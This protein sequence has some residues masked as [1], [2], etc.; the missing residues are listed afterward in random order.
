MSTARPPTTPAAPTLRAIASGLGAK[1]VLVYPAADPTAV[2][3][4]IDEDVARDPWDRA[5]SY[6]VRMEDFSGG[7][8]AARAFGLACDHAVA[9]VLAAGGRDNLAGTLD[10]LADERRRV[11]AD[12]GLAT[13]DDFGRVRH[14]APD[15]LNPR[16]PLLSRNLESGAVVACRYTPYLARAEAVL[17][18]GDGRLH[19]R[20]GLTASGSV[21]LT[22]T[23]RARTPWK[24]DLEWAHP[25]SPGF[26][27]M[28]AHAEEVFGRA[29]AC[30]RDEVLSVV[31][32]LHWW[33]AHVSRYRRGSAAIADMSCKLV[34]EARGIAVPA[35]RA[36]IAPDLEAYVTPLGEYRA[37]YPTLF[38]QLPKEIE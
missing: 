35:W 24:D 31:A 33:L 30:P 6:V 4:A 14:E 12:A 13:A 27:A 22:H 25:P 34:L 32:E 2:L 7:L 16:T 23:R 17:A 3:A 18:E 15:I 36:G 8:A 19:V 37:A 5:L 21:E 1:L 29:L 9:R 38:H 26:P 10:R 11:A 20:M 28:L